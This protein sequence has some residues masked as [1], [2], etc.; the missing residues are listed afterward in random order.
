MKSKRRNVSFG[1]GASSIMMIFVVLCMMILSVLS[2]S[3]ALQNES[4]A[5]RQ[6]E[7]ASAY[8]KADATIQMI[9]SHQDV[10]EMDTLCKQ[11][12]VRCSFQ[13]RDWKLAIDIDDH[14]ELYVEVEQRKQQ[15]QIT[16]YEVRKKE[17]K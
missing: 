4:I 7:K 17:D 12:E 6:K 1:L 10:K 13:D 16:T 14:Q 9:L 8:H 11:R 2:Y 15:M 5:N 3:K